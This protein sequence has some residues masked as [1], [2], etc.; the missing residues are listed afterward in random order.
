MITSQEGL[1]IIEAFE[2]FKPNPYLCP[3]GVPT[4]GIGST[5]YAD[6]RAVKLT[7]VPITLADGWAL[8]RATIRPYEAAISRFVQVPLT[9]NQFDALVSFTYNVGTEAFRTSTMLGLLNAKDYRGASGEF[10]R[11]CHCNGKEDYGLLKRRNKE[12]LLFMR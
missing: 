3:A 9:Q 8:L 12:A 4:I 5:H 7:D 2:G 1:N 10:K 6:G 11:F